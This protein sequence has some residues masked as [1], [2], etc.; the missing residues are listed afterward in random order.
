MEGRL[1]TRAGDPRHGP[2]LGFWRAAIDALPDGVCILGPSGALVAINDALCEMTGVARHDVIGTPPPFPWWPAADQARISMA[3]DQILR[4]QTTEFECSFARRD[5][6]LFPVR[7]HG[8]VVATAD[9]PARHVV[10][11][12]KDITERKRQ[13]SELRRSEQRWRSIVQNPFDFVTVIDRTYKYIYV[14]HTAPGIRLEDLI[15]KATPFDFVDVGQHDVLRS[16]FERAFREN[17]PTSYE[18]F[19]PQLDRWFG[20]VVGPIVEDDVVTSLSILTRDVTEARRAADAVRNSEHR[21]QLALA[22]G[23]VGAFDLD[24]ATGELYCS[25]HLFALLGYPPDDA[26]LLRT[27]DEFRQ[28]LHPDDAPGMEAALRQSIE[29]NAPF[30]A[31]YRLQTIS[32]TYRWFHGRGRTF[33]QTDGSLH[34]SGFV[35]DVT[36]RK[37]ASEERALL[38]AQLRHAQKLETLGTLAGG[39]AHDF[40]NLLVPILGNAQLALRAIDPSSPIRVELDDIRRAAEHAR[41]LVG[42]ILVF[43]RRAEERRERVDVPPL[44]REVASFLKAS[45]P[46][47]VVIATRIGADCPPVMGDP[48]QMHQA[49]TNVCTNA[50]QALGAQG[51]RIDIDVDA[52]TVDAA[53]GRLHRMEPGPS[54]CIA[55]KDTGPGISPAVL[56]RMF[57]P[58]FTTKRTS[59]GSGLGLAMVH[60]I[61]T[62]HGGAVTA[63]SKEGNG[64]LFRLYFPAAPTA[65]VA[66]AVVPPERPSLP[67]VTCR[68]ACVDDEPGVLRAFARILT[69][70]GHTVTSYTSPVEALE[71]ITR[72]PAAFDVVVSDLTMPGM[73]GTELAARLAELRPDLPVILATG[74]GDASGGGGGLPAN[75]RLCLEKPID[76]DILVQGI[77]RALS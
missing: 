2:S 40:N 3:H 29:R 55:V 18:A 76:V 9:E 10:L 73:S 58:F 31:E 32:G 65:T 38:E 74:Y 27:I 25:P 52:A 66:T 47:N 43:G 13:E 77:A 45:V 64:A 63:H 5:G 60:A 57:E 4:G 19:S 75:V 7:L 28:R 26:R 56:D 72:A 70:A 51:G 44:I 12:I 41:E 1:I 61:L 22:G 69:G 35:T 23:D 11:S 62:K 17:V 16:A 59:D 50:Y 8:A 46:S 21:L 53:F 34:F 6:S 54:V 67:V 37:T 24:I 48:N 49:L 33:P 15:G 14:N 20:S 30:D 39:I 42:R 68:I 71:A 36:E